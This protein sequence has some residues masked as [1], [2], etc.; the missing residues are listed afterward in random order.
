MYRPLLITGMLLLTQLSVRAAD[1]TVTYEGLIKANAL[2]D[3]YKIE[4]RD[5][6]QGEHKIHSLNI[7]RPGGTAKV[8]V[9]IGNM[10]VADD[11]RATLITS[12]LN[13]I[14]TSAEK[15]G[16]KI[17]SNDGPDVTKAD[18]S[19]PYVVT[20]VA[21]NKAGQKRY[22]WNRIFFA[23]VTYHVGVIADSEDQMMQLSK[24]AESVRER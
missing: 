19:K 23:P 9:L 2:P 8:L 15:S 12:D 22:F 13:A 5:I 7:F 11:D 17:I 18:L 20:L 3:G 16:W 1:K 4:R 24:W 21:A 6:T 14:T 10:L